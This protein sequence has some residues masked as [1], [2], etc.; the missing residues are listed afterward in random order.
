MRLKKKPELSGSQE[1]PAYCA[2]SIRSGR[3]SPL[4]TSSTCAIEF[5]EPAADNPCT[6]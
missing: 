6:T 1:G 5:S 3:I 2:R 4:S